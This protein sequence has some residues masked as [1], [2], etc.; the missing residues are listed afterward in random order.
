[1]SANR[2]PLN[3][4][5]LVIAAEI[6]SMGGFASYSVVLVQLNELWGLSNSEAGWL[7][8]AYY[9]GYVIAVPV[10]VGITDRVDA[11][12]VYVLSSVLGVLGG[13]GFGLF[14]D[15]F[16]S[17]MFFRALAGMSLAGTYMPGLKLLTERL[18]QA[19]RLRA[20]PYY[21]ASFG[22]GVSISFM[23]TGW[24]ESYFGWQTAFMGTG[25]S[26][27][28]GAVLV[29]AAVKGMPKPKE[30]TKP[31]VRRRT[32]D[33]RPVFG[34]KES[35]TY[36][37]AYFGHCWELFALRAWLP[38]FLLFVWH[39]SYGTEPGKSISTWATFIVMLGVPASILGAETAS[40]KG[41]RKLVRTVCLIS[42]GV[43]VLSGLSGY[44]NFYMA[45]AVLTAYN[46][47]VMADSGAIT[48]GA[49]ASSPEEIRGAT[50]AV[51]SILGFV[52]AGIGP[53]AVGLGLDFFGGMGSHTAW[54]TGFFIML[55]G[56]AFA[57]VSMGFRK[58][59]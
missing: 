42:V 12:R 54:V 25:V 46:F 24:L 6:F 19:H 26:S 7:S 58:D 51:H 1:M 28:A 15:G 36:I 27:L 2:K 21:T 49:F 31:S 34:N 29:L 41:R 43:G 50:L 39:M 37:L 55:A 17:G 45:V 56:S 47:A 22:I 14:A 35:M 48:T 10:L 32:L 30:E 20:V 3:L 59:K 11:V 5:L 16:Y 40:K 9:I 52:G 38:A 13:A 57:F 53:L 44:M 33:F 8:S 4:V 18:E 23:A